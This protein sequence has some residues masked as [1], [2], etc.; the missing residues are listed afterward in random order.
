M[1][2]YRTFHEAQGSH[3]TVHTVRF[4]KIVVFHL[5]TTRSL[6]AL[7]LSQ[8]QV[9]LPVLYP[10]VLLLGSFS[11]FPLF[12]F[13]YF[14]VTFLSTNSENLC[15]F[16]CTFVFHLSPDCLQSC[17]TSLFFLFVITFSIVPSHQLNLKSL[18]ISQIFK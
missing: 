2:L 10:S 4:K 6:K 18:I 13:I 16:L 15:H 3:S 12:S 1:Y 14:I 7:T 11:L 8:L 9:F 5:F 17:V